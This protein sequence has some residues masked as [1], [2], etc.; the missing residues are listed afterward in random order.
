MSYSS[1]I[2]ALAIAGL[3]I[4]RLLWLLSQTAAASGLGR[5][6]FLNKRFK[7]WLFGERGDI[8]AR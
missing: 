2:V 5:L 1:L 3:V 8:P 7:R 4:F 6:P